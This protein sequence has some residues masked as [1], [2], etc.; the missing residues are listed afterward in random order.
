MQ[1]GTFSA[2][3]IILASHKTKIRDLSPIDELK[4]ALRYVMTLTGLKSENWPSESQKMVLL[5]FAVSELGHFTPD[6][7]RIAFKLAS[8]KKINCEIE[9]YQNFN[10]SYLGKVMD[11]YNN[12]KANA[13]REFKSQD[14]QEIQEISE[15]DKTKYF[16][17]FVETFIVSKFELYKSTGRLEGTLSGFS[18]VF[19]TLERDLKLLVLS[20]DE[21]KQVY[22]LALQI[23]QKKNEIKKPSSKDEAR[24]IRQLIARTLKEG[25]EK[26]HENEIKSLCYEICV[27]NFYD[28]LIK[29]KRD[30]RQ[31]VEQFKQEQYE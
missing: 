24:M 19:N 15:E 12:Y 28:E 20:L 11:A 31:I 10:A 27:K 4:Q 21:K 18:A 1:F 14:V 13:M 8:S 2:K 7:I 9:H 25:Y 6:E 29:S 16:Y 23:H 3:E 17:E 22:D 30:L 26:V 5:D